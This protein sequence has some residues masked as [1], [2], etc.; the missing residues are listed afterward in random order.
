MLPCIEKSEFGLVRGTRL[1]Q[2]PGPNKWEIW[3]TRRT[4]VGR[5]ITKGI[6]KV[7]GK[8]GAKEVND[9][10]GGVTVGGGSLPSFKRGGVGGSTVEAGS[11]T[12]GGLEVDWEGV[13][14]EWPWM[15]DSKRWTP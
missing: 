3:A 6:H 9:V 7:G 5:Q 10:Q 8:R 4:T 11:W 13:S 12:R 14:P 1:T 2:E 15:W